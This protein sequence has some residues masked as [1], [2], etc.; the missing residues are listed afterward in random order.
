MLKTLQE[1]RDSNVSQIAGCNPNTARFSALI[2]EATQRL[3]QR[4]DWMGT[5]VP[6]SV[7]IKT[8]CIVFPRYVSTLREAKSCRGGQVDINNLW[9]SWVEKSWYDCWTGDRCEKNLNAYGRTPTFSSIYGPLRK[10]RAYAQTNADHGKTI[11]IFGTDNNN[12][13]LQHRDFET[14]DWMDGIILALKP[15]YVESEGYVSTITRV[16]KEETQKNVTLYAWNT[17]D[18]VLEELAL[19]EPG[20]TN[21]SFA[22][23]QFNATKCYDSDGNEANRQVTC[24]VKL[25]YIPVKYPNDLVLIDN[26][27]ALKFMVQAILSEEGGDDQGAEA[28]IQK[29]IQSLN[30]ALRDENFNNQIAVNAN[31][32]GVPIYSPI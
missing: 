8:G 21:P 13:P 11:T 26:I 14:G 22:R 28:K 17:T 32:V 19:Y 9:Y 30:F 1:L 31:S 3:M 27:A 2:N 29:A 25:Q 23:Y 18:S 7:C 24:L 15:G 10:V 4:G 12:Q 20:E 6:I 16:L 5:V